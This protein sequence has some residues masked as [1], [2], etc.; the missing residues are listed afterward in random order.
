MRKLFGIINRG[1]SILF[2]SVFALAA[3]K[4]RFVPFLPADTVSIDFNG[5]EILASDL[6]PHTKQL[7]MAYAPDFSPEFAEKVR[8]CFEKTKV[9]DFRKM[10]LKELT[11]RVLEVHK[12]TL[13][14]GENIEIFDGMTVESVLNVDWQMETLYDFIK[15]KCEANIKSSKKR[16]CVHDVKEDTNEGRLIT[17]HL[18]NGKIS[19]AES[20]KLFAKLQLPLRLVFENVQGTLEKN[21]T[22]KQLTVSME[23]KNCRNLTFETDCFRDAEK[24]E[25]VNFYSSNVRLS[26]GAFANCKNFEHVH[27]D[28]DSKLLCLP[29]N[30]VFQ[31]FGGTLKHESIRELIVSNLLCLCREPL[32][33]K[34]RVLDFLQCNGIDTAFS[35]AE[36]KASM[37]EEERQRIHKEVY[38]KVK[39]REQQ[40]N[41]IEKEN[42]HLK[43]ANQNLQDQM[44]ITVQK[45]KDLRA[46]LKETRQTCEGLSKEYSQLKSE[47]E[48]FKKI[49]AEAVEKI[50]KELEKS[51]NDCTFAEGK[52]EKYRSSLNAAKEEL[53]TLRETNEEQKEKIE[54]L[55][56]FKSQWEAKILTLE[57]LETEKDELSKQLKTAEYNESEAMRKLGQERAKNKEELKKKQAD[58]GNLKKELN[59]LALEL[60]ETRKLLS[61]AQFEIKELKNSETHILTTVGGVLS[62]DEDKKEEEKNNAF[63]PVKPVVKKNFKNY[64]PT[65]NRKKNKVW[66][67]FE[68]PKKHPKNDK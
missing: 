40:C 44:Q 54:S 37:I 4:G 21:D 15:E 33:D 8:E 2:V 67:N 47:Y 25:R 32:S 46:E 61:E 28:D 24:L 50:T 6:A 12:K 60:T 1:K 59:S 51:R 31:V 30:T 65:S 57:R 55:K 16:G 19:G 56:A 7:N 17:F 49:H 64:L 18:K 53:R 34:Q 23:F 29:P 20:Q 63:R 52:L 38:E 35:D 14:T 9:P 10:S 26:N 66:K 3:I 13:E 22:L 48:N 27:T 43:N 62:D 36:K 5:N 45:N 42:R 58:I 39:S 11:D 41:S 68:Y